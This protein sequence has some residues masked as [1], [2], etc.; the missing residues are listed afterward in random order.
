MG[1]LDNTLFRYS[2]CSTIKQTNKRVTVYNEH[3][4]IKKEEK[5][6]VFLEF[7]IM[8]GSLSSRSIH[9]EHRGVVSTGL[10][11]SREGAIALRDCLITELS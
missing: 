8:N 10:K 6:V 11:L 7:R 3:C 9:V 1:K 4:L 2:N 5:D